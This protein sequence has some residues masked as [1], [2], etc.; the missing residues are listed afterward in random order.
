MEKFR[1]IILIPMD[2][3]VKNQPKPDKYGFCSANDFKNAKPRKF[4]KSIL[5]LLSACRN[6][7]YKIVLTTYIPDKSIEYKIIMAKI[8]WI[9]K[10]KIPYSELIISSDSTPVTSIAKAYGACEKILIS[11]DINELEEWKD[12]PAI[13]AEDDVY[14][15]LMD[16]IDFEPFQ[17]N[18]ITTQ[19]SL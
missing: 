16:K 8:R 9:T 18:Y 3:L 7:G 10:T 4:V 17:L 14:A 1:K 19:D 15:Q 12:G 11:S 13:F 2:A 5:P 6:Q